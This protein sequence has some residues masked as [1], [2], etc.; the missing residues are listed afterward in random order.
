MPGFVPEPFHD[1]LN[2]FQ[3]LLKVLVT[4]DSWITCYI[5]QHFLKLFQFG[6][7]IISSTLHQVVAGRAVYTTTLSVILVLFAAITLTTFN[8]L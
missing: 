1:S 6:S 8:I 4:D 3:F 2:V 7:M 5:T